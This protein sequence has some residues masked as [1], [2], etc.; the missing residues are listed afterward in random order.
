MKTCWV[1]ATL[2]GTFKIKRMKVI[3]TLALNEESL[4][5]TMAI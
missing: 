2:K 3:F 1:L 5:K 4:S